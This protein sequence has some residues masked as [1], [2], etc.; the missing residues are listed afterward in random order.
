LAKF[1]TIRVEKDV[2]QNNRQKA[3][4]PV[5]YEAD[6]ELTVKDTIDPI[7]A[8]LLAGLW[9]ATLASLPTLL[10][11]PVEKAGPNTPAIENLGLPDA[12]SAEPLDH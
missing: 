10:L 11:K 2:A 4:L 3:G 1:D 7:Y 5:Y 6:R 12:G 8:S 9:M